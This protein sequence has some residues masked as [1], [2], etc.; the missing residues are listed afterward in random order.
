MGE[1]ALVHVSW[2][3]IL[4]IV[5]CLL[6]LLHAEHQTCGTLFFIIFSVSSSITSLPWNGCLSSA[7]QIT[8]QQYGGRTHSPTHL[9]EE[10]QDDRLRTTDI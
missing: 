5:T 4:T 3:K 6:I 8:Q 10:G 7:G 9:G 2:T 1:L